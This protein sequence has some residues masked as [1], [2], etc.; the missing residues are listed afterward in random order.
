[1]QTNKLNAILGGLLGH[2]VG[3]ALGSTVEFQ[4]ASYIKQ[5][6]GRHTEMIGGGVFRW[7]PGQGTDDSDLQWAVLSS[8]V[9]NRSECD[10]HVVGRKFL[11]WMDSNPPDI[12]NTTI[13]GLTNLEATGDPFKSGVTEGFQG[14]G[15][16]S[17]MRT[18]PTG[19]I[20]TEQKARIEETKLI[21]AITHAHPLC[22]G[23]CI[24][25]NEIVNDLLEGVPVEDAI[26]YAQEL[27]IHSDIVD[28]LSIPADTPVEDLDTDGYVLSTLSCAVWAIQQADTFE[29][30][31]VD[32]VNQG[33]DSDTTGAVAGGLLGVLH[34]V[35]AI[36]SRWVE[37]LEYGPQ[38]KAAA[39]IVA[40]M[41]ELD[42]EKITD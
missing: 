19:L 14:C 11:A 9:D 22:V 13:Q 17:L 27:D 21:S 36:P 15:N 2:A 1:M 26:R 12:G 6:Y 33:D 24:A 3:D 29:N 10:I 39:P 40:R 30:I 35:E 16:G 28:A 31:L 5:V 8:Y 20:R 42:A 7:R 34:T 32:L 18:L 23:S 38:L 4:D 25:Y 37:V 41:R